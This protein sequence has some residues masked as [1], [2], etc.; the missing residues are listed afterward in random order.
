MNLTFVTRAELN[1]F[2]RRIAA[3]LQR[4]SSVEYPANRTGEMP[5]SQADNSRFLELLPTI[6][7]VDLDDGLR[8]TGT[9]IAQHDG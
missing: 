7:S 4:S 2:I 1:D 6:V 5:S 9:W 3:L 8:Q